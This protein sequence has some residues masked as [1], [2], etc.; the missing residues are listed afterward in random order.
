MDR[1]VIVRL[2]DHFSKIENPNE[3]EKSLLIQLTDELQYF[4]ITRVSR[5]D[6]RSRGFNVTGVSDGDMEQ[7]AHEME[8][9]YVESSFWGDIDDLA[10][11]N[12]DIPKLSET[13]C[14]MCGSELVSFD[15]TLGNHSCVECDCQWADNYVL[16]EHPEDSSHFEVEEIGY[17][18]FKSEDN[19]ARYV[20]ERDYIKHF[21]KDPTQDRLFRLLMWPESQDFL[22][23]DDERC[24]VVVADEKALEDFGSSAIWVPVTLL[25]KDEQ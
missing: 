7:L 22:E 2:H 15:F 24:E 8:E 10:S 16:V 6:L 13:C 25:N 1:D 9:R 19:G 5:D 3:E 11:D 12:L 14:P 4:T 23:H 18:C 20:L 17:P 21:Q